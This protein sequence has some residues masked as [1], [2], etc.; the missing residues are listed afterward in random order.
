MQVFCSNCNTAHDVTY[1]QANNSDTSVINCRKCDKK[2]KF[3]FCPHC[4]AFY[5]ITFSNIKHGSY[6]YSCKK[7]MKDFAIEFKPKEISRTAPAKKIVKENVA[8][9]IAEPEEDVIITRTAEAEPVSFINNSINTFSAGELFK[10]ASEA[11]TVKKIIVSAA[12]VM[13]MLLV[14][15]LFSSIESLLAKPGTAAVN[16]FAGS[17]INLFPMAIIFSFYTL[18]ASVIAKITMDKIFHSRE[19]ETEEIIKFTLKTGP[20]V[21][22][23]NIII[24]L[25]VSTILILFG[26]IPFLG[27]LLF[28][29]AFLPVY[30]ISVAIFILC[31]IGLWFYPPVSAHREN[32]IVTNLKNLM[33]FIKK[34]NLNIIFM[35][36]VILLVAAIT[37]SLI[38]FIH[39]SAFSLSI[40]MS[41]WLLSN[42]ASMIF[43]SIPA[44]FIKASESTFAGLSSGIFKELNSS[45]LMTH[46]MG[47]FIL[48][49][50]LLAI[51]VFLLSLAVSITATVSSHIY[52]VMERGISIDDRKKALV[53]FI[54]MLLMTLLIMFRSLM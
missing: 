44:L 49:V 47:G 51:T 36:P 53:L 54:L 7:C 38:F 1:D 22:A 46:H 4:G 26:K 16:P 48:G 14:I 40:A 24:L 3:Q 13:S 52:I 34:H 2:I 32:G 30:L 41:K 37:F 5:S 20:G 33:L 27:P 17:L 15:Q 50:I 25:T 42:D 28:S 8:P 23:G 21:F 19:T 29:L 31:F 9:V 35:I 18:F 39:L 43:S 45:L 12:G 6:R 10:S 11:F